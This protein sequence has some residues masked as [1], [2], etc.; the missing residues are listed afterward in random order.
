M[1]EFLGLGYALAKEAYGYF[2]D[3]KE[4][5]DVGKDTYGAA[6]GVKEHFEIK[7]GEPKLVDIG[8]PEKSGFQAKAKEDGYEIA[9]SRPERVASREIDGYEAMYE[10]DKGART[11]RKL[12]L[13][14]GMV[15]IGRKVTA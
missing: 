15:L 3:V 4:V 7:D 13:Y 5:F 2:K 6:K 8:W 14:D 12:V 10:I 1:I 9:W 11:K